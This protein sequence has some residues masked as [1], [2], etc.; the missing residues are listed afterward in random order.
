VADSQAIIAAFTTAVQTAWAEMAATDA[1]MLIADTITGP[2]RL[3]GICAILTITLPAEGVLVLS[4]PGTTAASLAARILA[5]TIT[6]PDDAIIRDCIGEVANI[7]AGQAKT[8]LF[9]TP[10]HFY[11]SAPWPQPPESL[12]L[13]NALHMKFAS[14]AG[15]FALL[16]D[17]PQ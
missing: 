4:M 13:R 5:G 7:V 1:V 10:R 2:H 17:F 16:V 11:F 9:G 6:E 3:E 15:E 12:S 14:D 8:L